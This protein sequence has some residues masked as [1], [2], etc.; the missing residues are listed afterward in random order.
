MSDRPN[1]DEYFKN[2]V[3]VTSTRSSC[4]IIKVDCLFVKNN[5]IIVIY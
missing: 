4:S 1:W 3:I 2:I 5:R